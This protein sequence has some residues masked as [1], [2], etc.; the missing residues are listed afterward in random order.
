MKCRWCVWV[1]QGEVPP[2]KKVIAPKQDIQIIPAWLLGCM[3]GEVCEAGSSSK[4]R[5][6]RKD[7][8][9][10]SLLSQ[11]SSPYNGLVLSKFLLVNNSKD[12]QET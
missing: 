7:Q 11:L 8:P 12:T 4:L 10:N 2:I 5:R 1:W 9:H 6:L 3:S